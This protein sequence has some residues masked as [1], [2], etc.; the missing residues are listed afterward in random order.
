[1][2][3]KGEM[4]LI[5]HLRILRLHGATVSAIIIV[6]GPRD[7]LSRQLHRVNTVL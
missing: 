2:A 4:A 7:R 5:L 3:L 1:M 6:G